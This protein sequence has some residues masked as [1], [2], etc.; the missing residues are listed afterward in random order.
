MAIFKESP[1][2]S[3]KDYK[4]VLDYLFLLDENLKNTFGAL[5]PEDNFDYESLKKYHEKEGKV[6]AFSLDMSGMQSV[7]GDFKE[8]TLSQISLMAGEASLKVTKGNVTNSFNMENGAFIIKGNRLRVLC[9]NFVADPVT[10]Q[11]AMTGTIKAESGDI[12]GWAI[13]KSS[14]DD[15]YIN[16]DSDSLIEVGEIASEETWGFDRVEVLGSTNFRG[17]NIVLDGSDIETDKTTI[18]QDG[19]T[20]RHIDAGSNT[21]TCGA[22]RAYEEVTV[23]GQITCKDC[24]TSRDGKTWS[25]AR[26]KEKIKEIGQDEADILTAGLRPYSYQFRKDKKKSSGFIAQDVLPFDSNYGLVRSRDGKYS[27]RYAGFLPF[28]VKVVQRQTEEIRRLTDG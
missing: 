24:Y 1:V 11:Y 3:I 26:L 15:R 2:G 6:A 9:K 19:F 4:E 10:K 14:D 13:T 7:F 8:E 27:L 20:G 5:D 17:A 21:V 25:D 12:A 23:D 18:F 16:G 22:A 28:L